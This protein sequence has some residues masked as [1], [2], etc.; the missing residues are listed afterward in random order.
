[1]PAALTSSSLDALHA[2]QHQTVTI[3]EA[4]DLV[5]VSRRT[6]YNWIAAG[7]VRY[8]RTAGGAV[9]IFRDSLF[10]SGERK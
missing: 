8:V 2:T 7:K 9:R 10:Y 6:I 5:K 3:Y 4:M 1:M